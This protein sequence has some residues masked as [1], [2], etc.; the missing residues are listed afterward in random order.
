MGLNRWKDLTT[1]SRLLLWIDDDN[2]E[3]MLKQ[4]AGYLLI[5]S[6]N[7][8]TSLKRMQSKIKRNQRSYTWHNPHQIGQSSSFLHLTLSLNRGPPQAAWSSRSESIR[9]VEICGTATGPWL[10]SCAQ[11]WT[12]AFRHIWFLVPIYMQQR[13]SDNW[14]EDVLLLNTRSQFAYL[15]CPLSGWPH[16]FS[17]GVKRQTASLTTGR[18]RLKLC[19]SRTVY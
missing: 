5:H 17:T 2:N 8:K 9:N 12:L 1:C 15:R 3:G 4:A 6:H 11:N 7:M 10:C 18:L 13:K 19:S 14:W 16:I